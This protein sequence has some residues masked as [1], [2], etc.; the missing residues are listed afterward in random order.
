[1]S[2]SAEP[3]VEADKHRDTDTG[4]YMHAQNFNEAG[5]F[6]ARYLIN[7]FRSYNIQIKQTKIIYSHNLTIKLK[8]K[9]FEKRRVKYV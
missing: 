6:W 8:K 5:I 2:S 9:I 3:I 4:K 7:K 1:M